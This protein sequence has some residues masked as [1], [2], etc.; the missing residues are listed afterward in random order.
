MRL[1]VFDLDDVAWSLNGRICDKYGI[2][3]TKI[4]DFYISHNDKLSKKEQEILLSSY[5]NPVFF[6]DIQWYEGFARIFE[7]EQFGCKVYINS[8]NLSREIAEIKRWQ[9]INILKFPEDR[10]ILNVVND[11]RHKELQE[12][13][14]VLVED[15]PYNIVKSTA[16][17]NIITK[18]PWNQSKQASEILRGKDCIFC[19][20]LK[21]ELKII[22][23][24]LK[25]TK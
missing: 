25:D 17:Y 9:L 21:E 13:I 11:G 14:F 4:E 10:L 6:R 19:D 5:S 20:T 3:I 22:E 15:S 24:L 7:L 1:V 23:K 16:T 18:R 8:N 12:G 2:D